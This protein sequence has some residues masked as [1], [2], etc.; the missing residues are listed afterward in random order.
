M[1][2][3]LIVLLAICGA[4][5]P[6]LAW[7]YLK[8]QNPSVIA[9]RTA[10][11][12]LLTLFFGLPIGVL[13]IGYYLVRPLWT[14]WQARRAARRRSSLRLPPDWKPPDPR[15]TDKRRLA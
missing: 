6:W 10:G 1:Q 9:N 12:V 11:K 5:N 7:H 8:S 13:A 15:A 4:I 3:W 14:L 2:T